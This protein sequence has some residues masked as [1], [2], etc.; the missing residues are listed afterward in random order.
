MSDI[1]DDWKLGMLDTFI[2]SRNPHIRLWEIVIP[3]REGKTTLLKAIAKQLDSYQV[4]SCTTSER[5]YQLQGFV[6]FD[7]ENTPVSFNTL[8]L[9][10]D[11]DHCDGKWEAM[12]NKVLEAGGLV[13]RTKSSKKL[14]KRCI[15]MI[16]V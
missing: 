13:V 1:L 10:D 9:I 6:G 3:R 2:C 16:F 14:E 7:L 4:Y 11:Y 5:N 15:K 8:L 12:Q